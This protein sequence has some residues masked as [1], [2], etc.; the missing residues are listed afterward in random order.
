MLMTPLAVMTLFDG[1]ASAAFAAAAA[2]K[3]RLV[4]GQYMGALVLGLICGLIAPFWREL[5]LTGSPGAIFA[6]I[7]D[8]AFA[9]AGGG[10]LALMLAPRMGR[11]L[12][13]WLDS[14]GMGLAGCMAACISAVE[15]G[16]AGALALGLVTGLLP[17]L[18]RDISLGDTPLL[19]EESWY[20]GTLAISVIL[21]LMLVFL[22][23][24]FPLFREKTPLI[25]I[26]GGTALVCILRGFKG[27]L[28]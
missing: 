21:T 16:I 24:I 20:G 26:I 12:F 15:T 3:A 22:L 27:R 8:C 18:L 11:R 25:A 17:G 13:F 5:A 1:L 4:G 28:P 10:I 23:P 6:F 19:I 7:P 14:F 9:G 2:A